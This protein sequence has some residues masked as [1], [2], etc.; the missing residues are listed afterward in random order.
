MPEPEIGW[1][2][3]EITDA[4]AADPVSGRSRRRSSCS[5]G[6]T[7]RRRCRRARPSWRGRR[8]P[9]RRSASRESRPGGSSSTPRSRRENLSGWLDGWE[10]AEARSHRLRPGRRSARPANTHRGAERGRAPTRR[11]RSWPQAA[12]NTSRDGPRR[13]CPSSGGRVAGGASPGPRWRAAA[14]ARRAAAGSASARSGRRRPCRARGS[15]FS[16]FSSKNRT[17]AA[18]AVSGATRTRTIRSADRVADEGVATR[19]SRSRSGTAV[20]MNWNRNRT[21]ITPNT[22]QPCPRTSSR[23]RPNESSTPRRSITITGAITAQI[24]SRKRPGHDDAAAGRCR[25]RCRPGC[26]RRTAA[27]CTGVDRRDERADRVV[28]ATVEDVPRRLHDHPLEPVG[29]D[30]RDRRD[31]QR[32]R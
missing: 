5:N 22:C 32:R 24:V 2:E 10:E 7:T 26:P 12:P 1:Y 27:R 31:D 11:S 30:H 23:L 28:A 6:T 25:S 20:M 14:A 21:T 9:S 13:R 18:S 29:R 17:A 19:C 16:A 15:P 3:I 4:G 8:R